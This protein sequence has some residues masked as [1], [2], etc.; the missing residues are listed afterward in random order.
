MK[1]WKNSFEYWFYKTNNKPF[2]LSE[3]TP[4]DWTLT[5]GNI[6][7]RLSWSGSLEDGSWYFTSPIITGNEV[8]SEG[9]E[10]LPTE[11]IKLEEAQNFVEK[12]LN[13]ALVLMRNEIDYSIA[14]LTNRVYTRIING[15]EEV[16][17]TVSSI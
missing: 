6:W 16:V 3:K 7:A 4:S 12:K 9:V 5:L 13:Q 2:E 1:K 8:K 11:C 15:K 14:E 10:W 17:S